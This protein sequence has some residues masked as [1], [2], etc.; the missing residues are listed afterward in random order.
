MSKLPSLTAR[1]VLRKLKKAGF[2][3]DRQAKGSHEIWYNPATK[4]RTTIPHHPGDI[5][6]GTLKAI[7]QQ[8]GL[9]LSEFLD[10]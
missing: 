6:K 1:E 9:T 8:A 3:F 4:R 10:L 5:P 7:L 2:V